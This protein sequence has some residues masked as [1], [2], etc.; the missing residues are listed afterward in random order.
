[1]IKI[2]DI[3]NNFNKHARFDILSETDTAFYIR[4]IE[5]NEFF[6]IDKIKWYAKILRY[7][8]DEEL[9]DDA[10]IKELSKDEVLELTKKI[11]T[12]FMK[13]NGGIL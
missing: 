1:M 7:H 10:Y 9:D 12:L 4:N 8:I 2:N 6:T 13:I 5:D 11:V 3:V